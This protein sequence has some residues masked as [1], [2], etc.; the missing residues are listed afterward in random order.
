MKIITGSQQ[1]TAAQQA[2][3]S[4]AAGTNAARR[5]QTAAK[6][7][8]KSDTVELSGSLD[9]EL[10]IQQA[11]QAKRV[12]AIKSLVM[13]GKYQVDSLDVAE[14]MLSGSRK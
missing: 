13:A 9:S 6:T 14:K 7:E 5:Q 12:E 8:Q 4:K 3:E 1:P 11:A 10:K 2:T